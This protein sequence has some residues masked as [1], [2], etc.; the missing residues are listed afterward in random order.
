MNA[1]IDNFEAEYAK[2]TKPTLQV[3][4]PVVPRKAE[5]APA[6]AKVDAFVAH[7]AANKQVQQALHVQNLRVIEAAEFLT[8]ELVEP[9][10]Q[11]EELVPLNGV[12]LTY[13]ASKA[14]KSFCV[15]DKAVCIHLGRQWRDRTTRKGR[16]VIL[17]AEGTFGFRYRLQAYAKFHKIPLEDMPAV[18]TYAPNLWRSEEE[19]TALIASLKIRGVTYLAIDTQSQ[20]MTGGDESSGKDMGI[21]FAAYGRLSRELSCFVDA[22]SHTGHNDQSHA[23]G[24]SIQRPACD[25]EIYHERVPDEMTATMTVRKLKDADDTNA[26]FAIKMHRVELGRY[27]KSG[28]PY[29]SL[30]L[31]HVKD[32]PRKRTVKAGR[33]DKLVLE[34]FTSFHTQE[35][36]LLDL[37][38]ALATKLPRG[39]G[40]RDRRRS[41]TAPAAVT[42]L[43]EGGTFDLVRDGE[44]VRRRILQGTDLPDAK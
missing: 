26:V 16:A 23:R 38:E 7:D 21:V 31:E 30:A 13:G 42:S 1:A 3:V 12:G 44:A 20:I 28:K 15:I 17:V 4:Q 19:L 32:A 35:V 34:V 41:K 27:K 33:H 14:F 2:L 40:E 29:G 8:G 39:G 25:V 11:I 37:Y 6:P 43:I 24:S 9:E 10:W 18:I 36:A 22:I 5:Q